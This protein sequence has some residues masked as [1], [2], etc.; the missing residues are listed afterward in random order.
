MIQA[1]ASL[2]LIL[3]LVVLASSLESHDELWLRSE[4]LPKHCPHAAQYRQAIQHVICVSKTEFNSTKTPLQH[5]CYELAETLSAVLSA[6]I[7]VIHAT[8][9]AESVSEQKGMKGLLVV[10]ATV[11]S[12]IRTSASKLEDEA[13]EISAASAPGRIALTSPSGR[14]ALYGAFH[15]ISLIRRAEIQDIST[16]SV[17]SAPASPIRIWQCWDNLDGTI[18]RGYGGRSVFHY[19]ELPEVRGRYHAYARL[20]ASLGINAISTSNVNSCYDANKMLLSSEYVKKSAALAAVFA[21]YGIATF[22][23]PCYSS[24]MIEGVGSLETADPLDP[25]VV[26]WWKSKSREIDTAFKH[27]ADGV[28][29]FGGYLLKGVCVCVC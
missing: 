28:R 26:E 25:A 10:S 5:A 24:P 23:T 15:L 11:E 27:A 3:H 2:L 8:S 4:P 16:L 13:F 1:F 12:G 17:R 7:D 14:G 6:D 18:E 9:D 29:T 20:L 22:L 21:E 19:E